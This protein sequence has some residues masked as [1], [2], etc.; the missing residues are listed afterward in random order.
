MATSGRKVC[1]MTG[2]SGRLGSEIALS[3]AGQGYSVF[4][5]WHSS[6]PAATTLLEKI[7]WISPESAMVQCDMAKTGEITHAFAAF[8]KQFDR[9]DL[10][11]TS[12]SNFYS[13]PLP[14][15]TEAE[16]DS[17]VDTNLKGT[18]FTMQEA[19]KIMQPQPFVSRIIAMTDISAELVW[20][21]FAPYTV[22]KAG[23][24]HLTKIFAKTFAPGILVNA[25]APGTVTINPNR[26]MD[27]PE[28]MIRKIPLKRLGDPLDIVK[29][30]I[31]LLENDYITGQ[32]I[33]VDGGRLLQ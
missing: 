22:S 29:A 8:R 33:T 14:E 23:I 5:T 19:V 12:A 3:I 2:A 18:F 13:T 17:L 16:W 7:R 27:S 11:V 1:F 30:I 24:R 25:I 28:E 31:F 20:K 6:E 21:N 15:V 9:L 10:L 32:T 4:F 26:D